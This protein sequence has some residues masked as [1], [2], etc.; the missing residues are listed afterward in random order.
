MLNGFKERGHEVKL[1]SP[2]VH[3]QGVGPTLGGVSKWLGY[4]DRCLLFPP[5]IRRACRRADIVHVC[6]RGNAIYLRFLQDF[7]HLITC[8]D[9]LAVRASL[10]ELPGWT[11]GRSGRIYQDMVLQGLKGVG[12]IVWDASK[13]N[14]QPRRCLD[15]TRARQLFGFETAHDLRAGTARTIAWFRQHDQE[16]REVVYA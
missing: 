5:E 12:F 2:E 8:H 1:I 4:A 3:L 14:G 7:R 16:L 6:D 11:T 10:D 9:L 13:P 15:V